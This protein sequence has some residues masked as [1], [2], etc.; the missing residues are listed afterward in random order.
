MT[1]FSAT[2]YIKE[3]LNLVN[4]VALNNAEDIEQIGSKLAQIL[5]NN[6]CIYLAGNGGS[7][8]DAQHMAAE[9]IGRYDVDRR[10]LPAVSLSTDTSVITCISNDF[11]YSEIFSRQLEALARP[12]DAFF[13]IST[14]GNSRNIIRA[15]EVAN[16]LDLSCFGLLGG[17]GGPAARLVKN[18]VIVPT[19]KTG[20]I[21]EA[22]IMILHI[23][24][25]IIQENLS[26]N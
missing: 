21:Q 11:D 23:I 8:S 20:H 9:L 13:A 3:H 22:H 25:E 5:R 7:C 1:R 24:C 16:L 18:S 26:L 4:T 2:D 6:G 17:D 14:S 19:V 15:L 10:A 12:G